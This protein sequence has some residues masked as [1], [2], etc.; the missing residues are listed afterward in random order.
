MANPAST[1]TSLARR[2]NV[3]LKERRRLQAWQRD[4]DQEAIRVQV[5]AGMV[6]PTLP[7]RRRQRGSLWAVTMVKDE[8]DIIERVIR[9]LFAQGVDGIVVA[10]NRSTDET[11]AILARL[12]T[13]FPGLHIAADNEPAYYQQ[14]KMTLLARAAAAAGADWIIPFDADELWF[15][16]SGRLKEWLNGSSD[17]IVQAVMYNTF[18]GQDGWVLDTQRSHLVKVAFRARPDVVVTIGN[19]DVIHPG[20]RG[21]GLR[22]AHVPWRSFGQFAS[23]TRNGAAAYALTDSP[24]LLGAHWRRTGTQPEDVMRALWDDLVLGR[25]NPLLGWSPIGPLVAEDARE[26]T[27]WDPRGLL[28]SVGESRGSHDLVLVYTDVEGAEGQASLLFVRLAARLLGADLLV[29]EP[30]RTRR[31]R[32][33]AAQGR[34]CLVVATTAAELGAHH[35]LK[36]AR[37][38]LTSLVGYVLD[39]S[40]TP[41][42]EVAAAF[43]QLFVTDAEAAVAWTTKLGRPVQWLPFGTDALRLPEPRPV[44]RFDVQATPGSPETWTTAETTAEAME[45]GLRFGPPPERQG[46]VLEN[47][48]ASWAAYSSAVFALVFAADAP[49]TGPQSGAWLDALACG[50]VVA[51][52]VPAAASESLW[53]G[54]VV[55]L[56][57]D[58]ALGLTVLAE[59]RERWTV[60]DAHHNWQS[61]LARLDWRW[62]LEELREALGVP[63]PALDRELDRL[64]T[65]IEP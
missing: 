37:P 51:G 65:L 63:A 40:T 32:F 64:R 24:D 20:R 28:D 30:G 14:A 39:A 31:G 29:V 42:V 45:R 56:P 25:D 44:R 60:A 21:A 35:E 10:D 38:G 2:A 48:R 23:K 12:S 50:A 5:A 15:A 33:S 9:H 54:A 3:R 52:A 7:S 18:P 43:D 55:P 13:E 61:A 22:I 16:P 46:T 59:A 49:P 34:A 58:P 11:P 27:S 4:P 19:H 36:K 62:R 17:E 26:W 57:E 53:P 8:A 1:V 47:A 6:L 41:R